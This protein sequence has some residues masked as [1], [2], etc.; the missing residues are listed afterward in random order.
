MGPAQSHHRSGRAPSS[1]DGGVERI[2]LPGHRCACGQCPGARSLRFPF[3]MAGKP[4]SYG[5]PFPGGPGRAVGSMAGKVPYGKFMN[6]KILFVD[7][8][9]NFLAACERKFWKKIPLQTAEG[10]KA[11]LEKNTGPGP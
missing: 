1:P 7:E 3:E 4:D 5:L 11:G 10:G 8:D 6:D 2:F 9:P